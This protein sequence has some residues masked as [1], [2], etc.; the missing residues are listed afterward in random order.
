MQVLLIGPC[1]LSQP[2]LLLHGQ[3]GEN[4]DMSLDG[5]LVALVCVFNCSR[6]SKVVCRDG[7]DAEII[8]L[9][10]L[11]SNKTAL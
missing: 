7:Q 2:I 4:S 10:G 8:T 3:K 6:S 1:A 5:K 9:D 11:L